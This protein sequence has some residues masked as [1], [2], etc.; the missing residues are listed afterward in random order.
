MSIN[1]AG[2]STGAAGHGA[3]RR[4]DVMGRTAEAMSGG[5]RAWRGRRRPGAALAA[6]TASAVVTL[7]AGGAVA[8]APAPG[9]DRAGAP[10]AT[11]A[12]GEDVERVVVYRLKAD[13]GLERLAAALSDTL[14]LALGDMPG[15]A[16]VSQSELQVMIQHE[17]DK[18]SLAAC[19]DQAG[20]LGRLG[21]LT[22]AKQVVT[23]RVGKLGD[24]FAVTLKRANTGRAAVEA[25]EVAEAEREADLPE[26]VRAA[27]NRLM[28]RAG[29]GASFHLDLAGAAA[30]GGVKAAVIDLQAHGVDPALAQNLTELLSLE[31]KRFQGLSVISREEIKTMLQF[32]ADKQVLQCKSDTSCLMEIGGALGVDY[33]VTGSVGRLG[34][35]YVIAL[36][37][38][39]VQGA[40]VAHR[41]SLSFQGAAKDL[42]PALRV[43]VWKLLGRAV[44]GQGRVR[45]VVPDGDGG[46]VAVAGKAPVKL[47]RR[48]DF[49]GLAAGKVGVSLRADGYY[50]LFQETFVFDGQTTDLR[51]RLRPLPTPWYKEWWTWTIVGAV[52][53]GASVTT[54]VLASQ[55][56]TTPSQVT[57]TFR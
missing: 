46:R 31:L 50:P 14:V 8:A 7:W 23:G 57:A 6:L 43:A 20:C 53:V 35:A 41:T 24:A 9:E 30:Q 42:A 2:G 16:A 47:L 4:E 25:I 29:G 27:A 21:A 45:L 26:A 52:V 12:A 40:R 34:D 56:R 3:P 15:V 38:M 17:S 49:Q 19:G 10:G 55:P 32:E 28:G 18:Q 22:Q 37:L 48:M 5:P 33:L 54:A 39:D 51:P 13:K 44:R 11:T 1:D 36:K